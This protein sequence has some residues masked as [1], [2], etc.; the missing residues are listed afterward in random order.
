MQVH[1]KSIMLALLPVTLLAFEEPVVAAWLPVWATVSMYPLLLK[2]G[3]STAYVACLLLWSAVAP[4][5]VL[6]PTSIPQA[7]GRSNRLSASD[8]QGSA[9]P[10]ATGGLQRTIRTKILGQQCLHYLSLFSLMPAVCI[11]TAQ[12]VIKPPAKF[13]H[14]YDAA[15]VTLAFTHIVSSAAYLNIKQWT[16]SQTASDS[17]KLS[18]KRF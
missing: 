3:L 14:I 1:E 7:T 10:A 8:S 11:H 12:I 17:S 5:I 4:H 16:G 15:F 2:D 13:L 18:S 6:I 9:E